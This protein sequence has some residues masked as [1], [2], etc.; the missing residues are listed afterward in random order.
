MGDEDIILQSDYVVNAGSQN[1]IMNS[2]DVNIVGTNNSI[3]NSRNINLVGTLCSVN[4]GQDVTLTGVGL[5]ASNVASQTIVGSYNDISMDP[6]VIGIGTSDTDRR[7]FNM[8]SD[9]TVI[10]REM[11]R[12]LNALEVSPPPPPVCGC[13]EIKQFYKDQQCCPGR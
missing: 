10:V 4:N 5:I 6:F 3:T 8:R 2:D 11:K 7:N 1:L 9:H 12:R 13:S